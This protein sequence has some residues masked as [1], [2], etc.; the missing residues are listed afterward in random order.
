MVPSRNS[1]SNRIDISIKAH[2]LN[3]IGTWDELEFYLTKDMIVADTALSP[4]LIQQLCRFV[5][6]L[7][8]LGEVFQVQNSAIH[9]YYDPVGET[10]AF[11]RD[12]SL[13]FNLLFYVGLHDNGSEQ[14]TMTAFLYWFMTFCHE[15]AHNLVKHHSS[16]H[17]V[18]QISSAIIEY[19]FCYWLFRSCSFLQYYLSS[20][21][22]TYMP[23]LIGKM[24]Q[25]GLMV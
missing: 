9:V 12:N 2:S 15:L 4:D 8:D 24:K 13:F 7:K 23:I 6:L 25:R 22:E 21:A 5:I 1:W 14:P 19:W 10:I 20:Y 17:E 18:R 3:C 16:Q 11:N